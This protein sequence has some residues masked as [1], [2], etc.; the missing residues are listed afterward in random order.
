MSD[1]DMHSIIAWLRSEARNW[2]PIHMNIPPDKANFLIKL[3]ANV[4]FKPLPLPQQ[5]IIEPDITDAVAL[6]KYVANGMV[7]CFSCH[8]TA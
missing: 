1:E 5:P 8:N 3:L 2:L 4:A 6:G 7:G